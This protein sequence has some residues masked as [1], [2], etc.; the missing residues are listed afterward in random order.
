MTN[1]ADRR[2]LLMKLAAATA[3][4]G[5]LGAWAATA[6]TSTG[7]RLLVNEGAT[8]IVDPNELRGRYVPLATVL[9]QAAGRQV[10]VEAYEKVGDFLRVLETMPTFIFCK[11]VDLLA[12]EVKKGR[13]VPLAKINKPYVA[14]II[15][16]PK[17]KLTS[18]ADLRGHRVLLPPANVMTAKLAMAAFADAKVPVVVIDDSNASDQI[19][20]DK[21]G[22]RHVRWQEA[23]GQSVEMDIA[24]A[25]AVNPTL[26]GKWKGPVLMRLKP[27]VNWSL[28]V[29]ADTPPR[30]VAALSQAVTAMHTA[31]SG[32][33]ALTKLGIQQFVAADRQEFLALA[34][35][36]K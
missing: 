27:Q 25:G 2:A 14:G 9:G 10:E 36:V 28:G 26:L 12:T 21:V 32:Q 33:E 20:A 7:L 16:S 31:P 13:Y 15:A 35:Y 4:C 30:L 24:V 11:T 3:A 1:G 8:T 18:L 5:P 34:D 17:S 22:I 19:P 23:I 6:A 29:L